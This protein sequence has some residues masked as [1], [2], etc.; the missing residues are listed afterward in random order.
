[1]KMPFT[2]DKQRKAFFASRA[3]SK[4]S[5]SPQMIRD[6][7]NAT[8]SELNRK[9]IFLVP[10]KD[11]DKDGVINMKDCR[12][13]DPKR[14]GRLHDLALKALKRKEEFV[15]RRRERKLK[16]FEDLRDKLKARKALLKGRNSLLAE[17]QAIIDE[18]NKE[19]KSIQMIKQ[20]NRQ[21]KIELLK[22]S[23]IA[24]VVRATGRG[25]K[26]FGKGV[27]IAG[28]ATVKGAKATR[29]GAKALVKGGRATSRGI[30][31]AIDVSEGAL[32]AT[33]RILNRLI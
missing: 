18:F 10:T 8:M 22:T 15:E 11:A 32:K 31:R 9:G 25:G 26:A 2:T 14:Q 23:K 1:M 4:A 16:K 17:K 6:N 30:N 13:F 20:A 5:L 33:E 19:K 7:K 24:S 3:N 21:A 29:R 28:K 27:F 12:P